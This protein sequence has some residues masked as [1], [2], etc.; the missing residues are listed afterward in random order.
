[1]GFTRRGFLAGSLRAIAGAWL[2][3]KGL[4][5]VLRR[6]APGA[7]DALRKLKFGT[8]D[9]YIVPVRHPAKARIRTE[10]EEAA[11]KD[12]IATMLALPFGTLVVDGFVVPP[13]YNLIWDNVIWDCDCAEEGA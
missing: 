7:T 4:G 3:C 13:R 6:A 12:D 10:E 1:V 8:L 2:A 5:K 11:L 9:D